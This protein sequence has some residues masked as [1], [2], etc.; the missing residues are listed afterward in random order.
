M[1][2]FAPTKTTGPDHEIVLGT[3]ERRR[4]NTTQKPP[5]R[6]ICSLEVEFPEPVINALGVLEH[7]DKRWEELPTGDKGCGSGLLISSK[8][9]LTASHVL[10]GF[11]IVPGRKSGEQM[12]QPVLASR[13]RVIPGRNDH[14]HAAPPPFG[15]WTAHKVHVNPIFKKRLS[16]SPEAIT[17]NSVL[18]AL[19][20]DVGMVE[21]KAKITRHSNRRLQLGDKIG[22]WGKDPAFRILPVSAQR[23][24]T[25]TRYLAHIGGFPG[26]KGPLPCSVPYTSRGAILT[27]APTISGRRLDLLLYQADTS[28]G[29]SGSPVWIENQQG[30]KYLVGVH[31]SFSTYQADQQ[32]N[33][34]ALLT[35]P[36]M[37]SKW[38]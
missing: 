8:K 9:V 26:D 10:M 23:Q 22:W 24:K 7:R 35:P 33:I 32:V 31:S 11:K 3:D 14:H 25:L 16:G 27:A 34:G 29:M 15:V 19:P 1:T 12:L 17:K 18:A 13:V 5:F 6:W 37:Q 38:W 36:L 20:F 21:L 4:V 30:H 28:A 2:D